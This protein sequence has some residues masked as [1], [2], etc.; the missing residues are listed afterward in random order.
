MTK[1]YTDANIKKFFEYNIDMVTRTLYYGSGSSDGSDLFDSSQTVNDWSSEQLIKGLKILDKIDKRKITIIW[2]SNGGN[3]DAGMAV[4]EVI[5]TLRSKV[6]MVC[7]SRCRSMGSIILQACYKRILAKNCRFMIHYGT[8]SLPEMHSKDAEKQIE[9][10]KR[11]NELMEK[12]YLDK[13]KKKHPRFTL[14]EL[15]E[16]MKYDYYMNAEEAVKLGLADEII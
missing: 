15:R 11:I 5:R 6:T 13:I 9:E 7:Y 16:K 1:K 10:S 12:I 2:N 14:T 4:Y 3:W 8:E